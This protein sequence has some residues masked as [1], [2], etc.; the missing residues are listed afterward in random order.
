MNNTSILST[1]NLCVGYEKKQ[2]LKDLDL[3]FYPGKF[4][5]LLGPNGAGK[6]T[7]LRTLSKHLPPLSGKIT[8][9]G[10]DLSLIRSDDLARIMSVVLTQRV[11]PPLFRVYDFVGMGR[12]PHTSWTGRMNSQDDDAVMESLNLVRA[13]HLVFRDLSTLSDGERQKV[14]IAR[15]LA[16]EP[17]IILLDEPTMHLDLKHRMEVMSILQGLC[18]EKGICVVASLHDVEVAAKVSDRVVLIKDG[19]LHAFGSPED[20]LQ[21][22]TVSDLYDFSNACFNR[23]LGNIE[24]RNRA[25]KARVFV[26]GGM[27]SASVLYRLLSKK[28]YEVITGVL[29]KND[30]DYFVARSLGIQCLVQDSLDIISSQ[31]VQGAVEALKACDFIIDTGFE[32]AGLNRANLDL[33]TTALALKKPI[34]C[35][36]SPKNREMLNRPDLSDVWFTKTESRLVDLVEEKEIA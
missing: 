19:M 23:M 25:D 35:M 17:A 1:R 33:I 10:K 26:I 2:V 18:R 8:I 3:D 29:L 4:V 11:A 9:H 28:G 12:Y 31:S 14:L 20:V 36:G 15:A 27:G 32:T 5:S 24:I 13:Q 21:E 22:D 34:F 30:I 7:L 6:T 16:Q